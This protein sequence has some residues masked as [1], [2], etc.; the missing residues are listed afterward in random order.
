M[1]TVTAR[2]SG[3]KKVS[4]SGP[5]ITSLG[6]G[7]A[8]AA[9]GGLDAKRSAVFYVPRKSFA[10]GDGVR[11][12]LAIA[13]GARWP[14][15]VGRPTFPPMRCCQKRRCGGV[16]CLSGGGLR[17]AKTYGGPAPSVNLLSGG[18]AEVNRT[19]GGD[20]D[21]FGLIFERVRNKIAR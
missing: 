11:L 3:G 13:R 18:K 19:R 1:R 7:A 16:R 8:V 2:A 5:R 20:R 12:Q 9:G 17:R 14:P 4:G 21:L 6:G 15:H 10:A